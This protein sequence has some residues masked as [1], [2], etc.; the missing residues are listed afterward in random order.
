MKKLLEQQF[1][2]SKNLAILLN[3][4]KEKNYYWS[5]GEAYRTKEQAELYAKNGLGIVN[6]K[7]CD[8]LAQDIFL[9]QR[10]DGEN[11]RIVNNKNFYRPLGE[12]W[13]NLDPK[14]R[15]GGDF[16]NR[17]DPYHFEMQEE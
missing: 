2:F 1:I 12:I 11:W 8:R 4:M 13:K 14:N 16:T 7:H 5:M 9:F 10:E 3:Y 6:S 15:W 17:E